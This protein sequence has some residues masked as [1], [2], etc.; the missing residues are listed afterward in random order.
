[1]PAKNAENAKENIQS[2]LRVFCVFRGQTLFQFH[3]RAFAP[4]SEPAK[5]FPK[6]GSSRR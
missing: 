1:M 3:N 6:I 2:G 5:I 4:T